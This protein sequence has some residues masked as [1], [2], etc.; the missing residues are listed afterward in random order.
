MDNDFEYDD[1]IFYDV[2]T[3]STPV[4]A[5]L[6]CHGSASRSSSLYDEVSAGTFVVSG[7]RWGGGGGNGRRGRGESGGVG[8][9]VALARNE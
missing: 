1:D 9:G 4:P 2:I 3:H 5:D 6:G 8:G 7:G